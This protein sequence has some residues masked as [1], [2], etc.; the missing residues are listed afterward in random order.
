MRAS[1]PEPQ[2][3]CLVDQLLGAEALHRLLGQTEMAEPF[4][5]SLPDPGLVITLSECFDLDSLVMGARGNWG[6]VRVAGRQQEA[7]EW[8]AGKVPSP[9]LV[10]KLF[11]AGHSVV[12][13]DLQDKLFPVFSLCQELSALLVSGVNCN[14]YLTPARAQGLAKHYDDEDV[15]VVQ[16]RGAKTWRLY[17]PARALNPF[18]GLDYCQPYVDDC[19]EFSQQSMTPGKALYLPRGVP[20][21]AFC[22]DDSSL[23]LTFSIQ[24]VSQAD[25]VHALVEAVAVHVDDPHRLRRRLPLAWLK[26]GRATGSGLL[27]TRALLSSLAA[28]LD[29]ASLDQAMATLLGKRFN[30]LS[31]PFLSGCSELDPDLHDSSALRLCA[32]QV[33]VH[34]PSVKKAFF[35]GGSLDLGDKENVEFVGQLASR[36]VFLVDAL[37]AQD[38]QAR[39]LLARRLIDL[40]LIER[41]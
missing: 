8:I 33:L 27:A 30:G 23:H 14:A 5:W 35:K 13:N 17:P 9:E 28:D 37:P 31:S 22:T 10:R 29:A 41:V 2:W 19:Q 20:H 25:L 21:E 7:S 16:L 12:I 18:P 36:K 24:A 34:V 32:S 26:G 4:V 40:G 1:D 6:E 39:L 11:C 38:A 15:I 3:A